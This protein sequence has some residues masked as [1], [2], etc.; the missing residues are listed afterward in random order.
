MINMSVKFN[1]DA[2]SGSVSNVPTRLFPSM[3]IVTLVFDLRPK[4]SI[5]FIL[6]S[7]VI[8]LPS[9]IEMNTTVQSRSCSQ[10]FYH[11]S[12]WRPWPST[13]KINRV[14]PLTMVN[15]STKVICLPSL[16]DMNTTVQSWSCS[17]GF[18]HKSPWRRWPSTS[19]INKV[20]PFTMID[21][22]PKFDDEAYNSSISIVFTWLFPYMS[23]VTLNFD[24]QLPKSIR[25]IL[26][27]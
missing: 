9:L 14:H 1:E 10:G 2:H 19:K 8:C 4:N 7:W 21:F 26:S 24:L 22:S 18:Y 6:S 12:P 20:H 11:K 16:I 23:V 3:S 5:G 27:S 17:Q 13:S 25:F 15:L